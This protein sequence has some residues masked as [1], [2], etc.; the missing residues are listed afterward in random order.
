MNQ[1]GVRESG[2]RDQKTAIELWK[3]ENIGRGMGGVFLPDHELRDCHA[4]RENRDQAQRIMADFSRFILD[5]APIDGNYLQTEAI[6]FVS[7]MLC[8]RKMLKPGA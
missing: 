7:G 3:S 5:C 4:S 8:L 6:N 1:S 2:K